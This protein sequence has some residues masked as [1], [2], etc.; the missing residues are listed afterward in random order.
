M[1]ILAEYCKILQNLNNFVAFSSALQKLSYFLKVS[2][3]G[4]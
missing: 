3:N 2:K 1:K 4:L